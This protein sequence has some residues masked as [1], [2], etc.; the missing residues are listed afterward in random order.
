[1]GRLNT[2]SEQKATVAWAQDYAPSERRIGAPSLAGVKSAFAHD[3][4]SYFSLAALS[5]SR[6]APCDLVES[7]LSCVFRV[8]VRL[9]QAIVTSLHTCAATAPTPM[10]V[11]FG[12]S[13]YGL[14]K[15][16]GVSV[17]FALAGCHATRACANACYAHDALDAAP[18]AV[19]RGALNHYI[20]TA[21]ERKQRQRAAI[22]SGLRRHTQRAVS[23]AKAEAE[24]VVGEW[25]R[26]PRI[27]FAH[28]A[29]AA[30]FPTFSNDLA[31]QVKEV[32]RLLRIWRTGVLRCHSEL[33][34][35]PQVDPSGA[36]WI[37]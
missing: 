26:E 14:S 22:L 6:N 20:A 15:K 34:G 30:A 35:T 8:R 9:E 27:R 2:E 4:R 24:A 10:P 12:G 18:N 23:A 11:L 25:T 31:R 7:A 33:S 28:V 19:I 36:R 3:L 21:Y 17:R 5:R 37:R 13:F 16:Q 32:S 29:E 1:V